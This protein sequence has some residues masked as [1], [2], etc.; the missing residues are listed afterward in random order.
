M[1]LYSAQVGEAGARFVGPTAKT[2]RPANV[3]SGSQQCSRREPRAT[4]QS[5]IPKSSMA[6]ACLRQRTSDTATQTGYGSWFGIGSSVVLLAARLSPGLS[7]AP[8]ARCW[9]GFGGVLEGWLVGDSGH[10]GVGDG[11]CQ[12]SVQGAV[13]VSSCYCL[14]EV[15][16]RQRAIP[17][18]QQRAAAWTG[19]RGRRHSAHRDG[20]GR[21]YTAGSGTAD[22]TRRVIF[23][24]NTNRNVYNIF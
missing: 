15:G 21:A 18:G 3:E 23:F 12:K 2:A 10:R 1:Q 5:I 19:A 17:Y 24:S 6:F 16:E 4:R 13:S 11:C 8:L 9:R 20:L 22:G 7:W 14:F